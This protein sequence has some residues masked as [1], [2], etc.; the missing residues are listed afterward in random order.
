MLSGLS[1]ITR[2]CFAGWQNLTKTCLD[3]GLQSNFQIHSVHMQKFYIILLCQRY[4]M[5]GKGHSGSGV[6]HNKSPQSSK[7]IGRLSINQWSFDSVLLFFKSN[8]VICVL[9][10]ILFWCLHLWE[11]FPC[12]FSPPSWSVFDLYLRSATVLRN[13]AQIVRNTMLQTI[14]KALQMKH[15]RKETQEE[16]FCIHIGWTW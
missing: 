11:A 4:V 5:S 12:N 2:H 8:H 15:T 13:I 6:C 14:Y 16:K 10:H 3:F 1:L 7:N 9:K